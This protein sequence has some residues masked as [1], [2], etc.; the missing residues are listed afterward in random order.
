MSMFA[1]CVFYTLYLCSHLMIPLVFSSLVQESSVERD[2]IE[3]PFSEVSFLRL[4][5]FL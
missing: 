3:D 5:I 4:Q 2:D 1:S